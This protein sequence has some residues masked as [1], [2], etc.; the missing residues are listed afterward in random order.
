MACDL[1]LAGQDV[2]FGVPIARMRELAALIAGH[3]PLT[4]RSIKEGV[5]AFLEKRAPHRKGR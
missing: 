2:T 1:R 3:A 4:L 5:S